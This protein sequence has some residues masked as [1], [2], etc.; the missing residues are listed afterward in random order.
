[1]TAFA[2]Y[3]QFYDIYYTSKDYDA[4]AD[5]VL[6]LA[7]RFHKTP[8][9]VLDMG[10]GTGRHI[11]RLLDRGLNC[12]GFDLSANMLEQARQR[13]GDRQV[14]LSQADV[15]SFRGNETYD[16]VV[17]LF[18]VMGYLVTNDDL[19][20][21]LRTAR[22]QLNPGG[23]FIFDGW[24]GPA[25][26]DQRP[27]YRRHE[28]R[29]NGDLIVREARPAFDAM[30][31]TVTVRYDLEV[32][33]NR[34]RLPH[35]HEEHCMRLM[36]TQEIALAA[37]AAG[38]DVLHFCP[39]ME[40]EAELSTK[41]W[42][43]CFVLQRPLANGGVVKRVGQQP[44]AIEWIKDGDHVL[45]LIISA[46]YQ[47]QQTEFVSP[48]IIPHIHHD[49]VRNLRGTSETLLVRSGRCYVDFYSQDRSFSCARELKPGDVVAL[50]SGGHG[51]RMMERT[52][53]LEIKQGP[54][55]GEQEKERFVPAQ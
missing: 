12:D 21:G 44:P 54:Y 18:A 46:A 8:R 28:Y 42:N 49:L 31:Q 52:V 7:K 40:P 37:A 4:E 27:E 24:F 14:R 13:L 53:F 48:D 2:D 43:V 41:T 10:C 23:L 20:A 39:F 32:L 16:L 50:I 45:G 25:V 35:I 3:A 22:E 51:F 11:E 17:S 26:L 33:R 15:T 47:P 5:F 30:N 6:S 55:I 38:L 19:I 9:T 36:F 34:Q 29:S 1:V